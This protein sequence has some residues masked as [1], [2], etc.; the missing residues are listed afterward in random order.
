MGKLQIT[1]AWHLRILRVC[2]V[3]ITR[4]YTVS[5]VKNP[6]LTCVSCALY[7]STCRLQYTLATELPAIVAISAIVIDQRQSRG[8]TRKDVQPCYIPFH[9]LPSPTRRSL[10]TET[11]NSEQLL[12]VTAVLHV[13]SLS[14]A[15]RTALF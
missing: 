11:A 8:P 2:H 15:G 5:H 7:F 10:L 1:T 9:V 4:I 12:M 6:Y 3:K 13:V 14:R